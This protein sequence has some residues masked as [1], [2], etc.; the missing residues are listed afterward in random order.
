MTL[1]TTNL[2]F[3]TRAQVL[4][5]DIASEKRLVHRMLNSAQDFS[6]RQDLY[7]NE[8]CEWF[9]HPKCKA[10]LKLKGDCYG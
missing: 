8:L 4:T 9:D 2:D 3:E 10:I 7:L 5:N 1:N 6:E